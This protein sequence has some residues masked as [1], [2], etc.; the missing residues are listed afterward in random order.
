MI[1]KID[2]PQLSQKGAYFPRHWMNVTLL[3]NRPDDYRVH[4]IVSTYVRLVEASFAQYELGRIHLN[5]F[6]NT[7]NGIAMADYN[8]SGSH[9][10]SCINSMH[11]AILCAKKIRGSKHVPGD[12]KALITQK[13]AFLANKVAFRL[14]KIRDMIQHMDEMVLKGKIEMGTS[15]SLRTDGPEIPIEDHDQP[16]QTLKTIDRL[17]LGDQTILMSELTLWLNEMRQVADQIS[18]YEKPN[19]PAD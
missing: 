7:H 1:I 6:W 17:T 19:C 2:V 3:D 18:A 11:R 4:A 13:P 8:L 5:V 16:N 9:F 14:R 12:I 10:E 15:F